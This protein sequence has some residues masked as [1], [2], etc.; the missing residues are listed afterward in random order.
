MKGVEVVRSRGI[1]KLIPQTDIE[2]LHDED[3]EVMEADEDT[4]DSKDWPTASLVDIEAESN[5]IENEL[6]GRSKE[7]DVIVRTFG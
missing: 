5:S 7:E 6:T 3:E 2:S 1:K 4:F